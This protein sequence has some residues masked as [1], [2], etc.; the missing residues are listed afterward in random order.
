MRADPNW[1]ARAVS[2]EE[3]VAHI[4]SGMKV[5]IHGAAATPT[6]LLLALGR[7]P[8]CGSR[9]KG[10]I[11]FYFPLHRRGVAEAC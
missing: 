4:K 3:A 11:L 7:H 2:P 9:S 5:F 8:L 6:L 10:A 1:K